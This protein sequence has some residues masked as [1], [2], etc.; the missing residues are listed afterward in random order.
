MYEVVLVDD[1][2]L[3][4]E[5]LKKFIPWQD[6]GFQV[7][8]HFQDSSAAL[9]YL[10]ENVYDLLITD[11]GMPKLNGIELIEQLKQS[12]TNSY[13]VI[14]SCHG[15]FH[16]AQQAIK[17]G[18][19][20]YILKETMEET[21]I[22]ELLERLKINLDQ[23]RHTRNRQLKVSE[24]LE[25]N[26]MRS[27]SKLIENLIGEKKEKSDS[28]KEKEELLGMNFSHE[29]YTPVLC[30]IDK[31]QDAITDYE[32]ETLLQFRVEEVLTEVEHE[33]Q[34]FFLQD[35]FFMLFPLN[36]KKTKETKQNIERII[37][38]NHSKIST[39]LKFSI[40]TVMGDQNVKH[41]QLIENMR[42]LLKNKEQ[43]FYYQYD[44]IQYFDPISFTSD[45]IFQDYVE[46]SQKLKEL[47]LKNQK[48]Q[49]VEC[50]SQQLSKIR[51][52]KYPPEAIKD[53]VIKLIYDIKLSLNALKHFETQSIQLTD[54][55]IQYVETF[56]H[57]E[58]VLGE[59]FDKFIEQINSID[60]TNSNEDVLKAQK[61]VQTHLGEKISLTE[62]AAHLHLNAS[63]LSRMYKKE[64]GE[65]FVEYV[66][67]VKMA[68]A[69]ELLE[70]S[71]KSVEQIAY[72]LGFESKSY[73]LKTFK[74]FYGISPKAYKYKDKVIIPTNID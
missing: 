54:H 70:H 15:E 12:K 21:N 6:Y 7:V 35:K 1:D 47:I 28:W 42:L 62:V 40:T 44:S 67:R 52:K 66:T 39:F 17:L 55:F 31:Y 63:Y 49:M 68:K 32:N 22:I 4:I 30:Y 29:Q 16:F 13:N 64:T 59:I 73:F 48:D 45:S 11:I 36:S 25:K 50:I 34:I 27:R 33:V 37:K 51:E 74:R 69:I 5:F 46:V 8:A 24:F 53:W 38:E 65:G 23:E 41:Q 26:S 9:A 2:A 72:E 20:D 71:T 14:L 43:R 10:Q 57:L 19:Y 56:E 61:Y 18:A 58:C 60:L 3:V